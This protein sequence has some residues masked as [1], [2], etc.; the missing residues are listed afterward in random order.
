MRLKCDETRL[1]WPASA[2]AP[3][4]DAMLSPP[5]RDPVVSHEPEAREDAMAR[6]SIDRPS[7]ASA[8]TDGAV[9]RRT[10]LAGAG[11]AVV[12]GLGAPAPGAAQGAAAAIASP[13]RRIDAHTHFSS[14]KV[15]DPTYRRMH[16]LTDPQVRLAILDRN[17]V[18]IHVLVP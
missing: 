12:A 7:P 6:D 4:G 5:W 2:H 14:L 3:D 1:N 16:A 9:D 11:S 8:P 17:E 18:D 13:Y 15:L 10:L